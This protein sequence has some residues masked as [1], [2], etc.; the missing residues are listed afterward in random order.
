MKGPDERAFKADVAKA[1]FR[2]GE[3]EGRWRL[4]ETAWPHAFVAVT[5]KDRWEYVLRLDCAGYPQVP[6]D[7]RAVGCGSE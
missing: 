2:L 6:A 7:R 3:V 5:A 1:A 4:I